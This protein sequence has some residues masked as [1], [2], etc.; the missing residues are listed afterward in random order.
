[1]FEHVIH[2]SE[3]YIEVHFS[4]NLTVQSVLAYLQ[5]VWVNRPEI[6][7]FSELVNLRKVAK[8]DMD[9]G[10]L[11][12]IVEAGRMLDD[13]NR[14]SRIALVVTDPHN[15]FKGQLYKTLQQLYPADNKEVELFNDNASARRWLL[16][17]R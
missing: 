2:E 4:G 15:F 13:G 1:M 9:T 6:A 8:I 11:A 17:A 7:G 16:E 12:G 3:R 5:T 14:R 10:Q